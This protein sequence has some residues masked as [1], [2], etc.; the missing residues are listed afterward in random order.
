MIVKMVE[1]ILKKVQELI[2][3]HAHA[4]TVVFED[5]KM[6]A[7]PCANNQTWETHGDNHTTCKKII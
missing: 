4:M 3:I 1:Y 2:L 6:E 5:N 7:Q